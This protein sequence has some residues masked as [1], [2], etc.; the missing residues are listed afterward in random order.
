[1]ENAK[2][3]SAAKK[4]PLNK[5]AIAFYEDIAD[6]RRECGPSLGIVVYRRESYVPCEANNI[7]SAPR[8]AL[9]GLIA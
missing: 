8:S 6:N 3:K 1:M 4:T 9:A 5:E 7:S 2:V